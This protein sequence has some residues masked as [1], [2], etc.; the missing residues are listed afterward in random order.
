M[1]ATGNEPPRSDTNSLVVNRHPR[2]GMFLRAALPR[3]KAGAASLAVIGSDATSRAEGSSE[4]AT[5][6]SGAMLMA[7]AP[8]TRH[9]VFFERSQSMAHF[10]RTSSR[11][12]PFFLWVFMAVLFCERNETAPIT[13]TVHVVDARR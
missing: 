4:R 5:P 10:L 3:S 6:A 13:F 1:M 12:F 7:V 8:T 11:I 9:G 2:A